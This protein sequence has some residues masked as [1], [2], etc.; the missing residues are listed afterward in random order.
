MKRPDHLPDFTNP[1]LDEVVLGVQFA[2][3]PNYTS[4]H[5]KKVWDIFKSAFPGVQEHPI[6]EPQFETFGGAN[7]Q[8]GPTIR[9]GAP[10]TGSRLW[11]LSADGNQLVQFQ[12]DRFITNWRKR[13]NDQPY[14]RFEGISEAFEVN[15]NSLA[16]HF[17]ADFSFEIDINQAEVAYINIIPVEAFS[18]A[19]TWFEL[20][21]SDGIDVEA[22]S[23]S[24]SEVIR[25]RDNKPFAR[26]NH[27]IQ[28]VFTIDGKQKAFRLSL[29][30]K[31]KPHNGDTNSA[32]EFLKIGRDAIVTRFG[33]I[34]TD[35]AHKF[36]EK[37]E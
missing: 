35:K 1:P 33:E 26:L 36:W 12:P 4:V 21:S 29:S 13:P 15:L 16:Q 28:S 10:A 20:W 34:T 27:E 24:F 19:G 3:V 9:V 32:M 6:L 25:G 17:V 37:V 22:L 23:T 14:P 18:H 30:F 2:P 31:G 5:S 8:V 11:F 7:I